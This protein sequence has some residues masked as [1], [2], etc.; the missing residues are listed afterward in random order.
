MLTNF[1]ELDEGFITIE[2]QKDLIDRLINS[3]GPR[4]ILFKPE[5]LHPP[6][7]TE[8][9]NPFHDKKFTNV[10][11]SKT[12]ITGV[13]FRN[14]EFIDCLFLGTHFVDCRFNDCTF[15]GCNPHR[16]QFENTYIDPSVFVGMLDK[17]QHSN[18]GINLFHQLYDNSLK[19][20]QREFT[21]TAEFNR[22]KWRRY[23]LD[24]T[25][26]E[27][28]KKFDRKYLG[29]WF[30]NILSWVVLGYGI[31]FRF[32]FFWMLALS[33]I[34]V[35][36]NFL[37]WECLSVVGR[38]GQ[39]AERGIVKV[40]YYTATIPSGLGDFTPASDLGKMVFLGEGFFGF[41]IISLFATWLVRR[42]LR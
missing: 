4:D 37:W 29:Q 38:D 24:Y 2:T 17:R 36:T 10:S 27:W 21:I 8:P 9:D 18:I 6:F 16:V 7:D 31:R 23:S 42:C 14:C 28:R 1:F 39:L 13:F 40:L 32:I 15:T 35:T 30:S 25:H 19:T 5:K 20:N 22:Q 34:S 12:T 11:F 41:A 33:A 26:R 3:H